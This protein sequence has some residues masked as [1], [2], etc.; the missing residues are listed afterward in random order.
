MAHAGQKHG[1]PSVQYLQYRNVMW[2]ICISCISV[3]AYLNDTLAKVKRH[4]TCVGNVYAWFVYLYMYITERY[5][6]VH[7]QHLHVYR[8]IAEESQCSSF[9]YHVH[10]KITL[11][12]HIYTY[13]SYERLLHITSHFLPRPRHQQRRRWPEIWYLWRRSMT[14]TPV[15]KG[16]KS[17]C[18]PNTM[19][20]LERIKANSRQTAA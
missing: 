3:Y 4:T 10:K 20:F 5:Y 6:M 11:Y 14:F 15:R 18:L 13:I 8:Y 1:H 16:G 19:G 9:W 7:T 12:M 17:G 2:S